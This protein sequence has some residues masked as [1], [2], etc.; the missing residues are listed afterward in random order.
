MFCINILP[1]SW[2][3]VMIYIAHS[4]PRSYICYWKHGY[5]Q[6]TMLSLSNKRISFCLF[7]IPSVWPCRVMKHPRSMWY[8]SS[9]M[10]YHSMGEMCGILNKLC[11]IPKENVV[12]GNSNCISVCGYWKFNSLQHHLAV[13]KHLNVCNTILYAISFV[14]F[15]QSLE[16]CKSL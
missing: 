3:L 8:S 9:R 4:N 5:W 16:L 1:N 13:I 11:L 12:I 7:N 10:L 2:S 6:I 14:N 15:I